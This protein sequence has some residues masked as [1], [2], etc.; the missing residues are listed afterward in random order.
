MKFKREPSGLS[1]VLVQIYTIAKRKSKRALFVCKRRQT[2][3]KQIK[4]GW[5]HRE[6]PPL[7]LSA[8]LQRPVPNRT[9][10]V[11]KEK[12][13]VIIPLNP[14]RGIKPWYSRPHERLLFQEGRKK[15]LLRSRPTRVLILASMLRRRGQRPF[16]PFFIFPRK[17]NNHGLGGDGPAL[18]LAPGNRESG[19][20]GAR[21][22]RAKRD[23]LRGSL[24]SARVRGCLFL[25]L[26]QRE[27]LSSCYLL[28]VTADDMTK[29]WRRPSALHTHFIA[30]FSPR[31]M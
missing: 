27:I 10:R 5:V 16:F 22:P 14:P 26:C 23:V 15:S 3:E 21:I 11:E 18:G 25:Q 4:K 6:I 9:E 7:P 19:F 1:P 24:N 31:I 17:I 13:T 8:P 2:L 12:S 20:G 29:Y 30:H 28:R